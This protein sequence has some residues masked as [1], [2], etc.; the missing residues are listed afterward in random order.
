MYSTGRG[1]FTVRGKTNIEESKSG[2][3]RIIITELPYQVNKAMLVAR[4]AELAKEKKIEG[5]SDL[6]DESDRH[7]TRVVIDIPVKK[8]KP[9]LC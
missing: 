5:I 9:G 2:R 3:I 1:K 6:R 7:G 4:I 8:S